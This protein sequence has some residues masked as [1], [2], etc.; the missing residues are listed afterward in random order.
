MYCYLEIKAY[1]RVMCILCYKKT[2]FFEKT[3]KKLCKMTKKYAIMLVLYNGNEYFYESISQLMIESKQYVNRNGNRYK[4]YYS[5]IAD[6][7]F[8]L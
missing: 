1:P 7:T 6:R 4:I 5:Y 2:I 3:N 8:N